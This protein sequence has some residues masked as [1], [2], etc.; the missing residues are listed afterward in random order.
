MASLSGH[1][2]Q[3]NSLHISANDQYLLSS[4]SDKSAI[5]WNLKW[6]KKGEKLMILDRLK[7]NS[8]PSQ[9]AKEEQKSGNVPFPDV[10]RK[11]QFYYEDNLIVL[12]SGPTLYYY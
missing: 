7:R 8:I 10:I 6:Q 2:G 1:N 3:I 5:V 9:S 12:S 11:A 4:S